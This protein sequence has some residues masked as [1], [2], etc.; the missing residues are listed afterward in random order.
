MVWRWKGFRAVGNASV[1]WGVGVA[2]RGATR[3]AP[4]GGPIE[5]S[6]SCAAAGHGVGWGVACRTA[7]EV[8]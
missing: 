3:R 2:R 7:G 5:A 8:L 6:P 4:A 1:D